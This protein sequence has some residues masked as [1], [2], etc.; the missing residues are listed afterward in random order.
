MLSCNYL[1]FLK[2]SDTIL[3]IMYILFY[4]CYNLV[5]L[6]FFIAIILSNYS[7][8]KKKSELTT[9]ALAR[10]STNKSKALTRKWINLFCMKP[11]IDGVEE[12]KNA[13]ELKP[14]HSEKCE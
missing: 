9:V 11:P 4:L 5:M 13:D 12:V 1:E 6:I 3:V 10:L 8:L 7:K 14:S 2:E